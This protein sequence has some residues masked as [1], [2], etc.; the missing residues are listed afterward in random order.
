M[1]LPFKRIQAGL[2]MTLCA[3]SP[4]ACVAAN[5]T[6][7]VS[8]IAQSTGEIGCAL[9]KGG[10]GFPMDNSKATQIWLRADTAGVVCSFSDLPDGTY[11]VAVSQ[12]F[13][14]NK[15]VDTNFVGMPT[16]PWGASNNARPLLR[17][18]RFD[19]AS[20]KIAGDTK[21]EIKVAK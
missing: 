7:N 12:D 11:A 17:A 5:L 18:P 16:E 15:K 1:K 13:N 6:V 9:Y 10:D 3:L 14:G 20:F 2:V 8:G 21:I 19:E 4:L